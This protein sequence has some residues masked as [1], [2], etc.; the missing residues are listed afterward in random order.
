MK[1]RDF[2]SVGIIAGAAFAAPA[3]ACRE[4]KAKDQAGYRK[5]VEG[6]F[7][8]WFARDYPAFRKFFTHAEV[9]EAF[10]SSDIFHEYYEDDSPNY[11]GEIMFNGASALVQ[12][13]SP[14][15][16]DAVRGICGGYA[17]GDVMLVRFF[18]GISA[19]VVRE[20]QHVAGDILAKSEWPILAKRPR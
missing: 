20:L 10:A 3:S 18:P 2:L 14:Q 1:R 4:P 19:P 8:A 9:D 7:A 11:F 6:L 16:G 5:V 17:R 12:V 15:S 13:V